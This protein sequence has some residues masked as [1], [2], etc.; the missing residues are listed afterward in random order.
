[1]IT[2]NFTINISP[3]KIL[4]A[5]GTLILSWIS[6]ISLEAINNSK[7]ISVLEEKHTSDD[8]QDE[9][10]REIR[11]TIQDITVLFFDQEHAEDDGPLTVL[12][13]PPDFSAAQ[14]IIEDLI[15]TRTYK[16]Q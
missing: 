12:E 4:I 1:M 11:R 15:E 3:A 5:S 7:S 6:Y 10:L 9:E 8:R 16:K 2:K 14:M 13:R